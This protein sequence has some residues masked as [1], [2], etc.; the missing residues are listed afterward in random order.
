MK[1]FGHN[2]LNYKDSIEPGVG[3]FEEY[4]ASLNSAFIITTL[5]YNIFE[6]C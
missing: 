2:Y 6:I 1:K 4:G 3:F 5:L